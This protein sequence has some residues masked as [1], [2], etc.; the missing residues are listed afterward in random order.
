MLN[1]YL[2]CVLPCPIPLPRPIQLYPNTGFQVNTTT[3]I[4]ERLG[5]SQ[6][7]FFLGFEWCE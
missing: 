2:E 5:F 4:M 7:V 3:T 1:A 6:G